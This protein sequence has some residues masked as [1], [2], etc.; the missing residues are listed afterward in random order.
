MEAFSI[1]CNGIL[2]L[3]QNLK[4][5][6]AFGP[7][8]LK[9]LLLKEL[10]EEIAPIIQIIFERSLQTGKLPADWCKAQ[11]I[12]VF[13]K[14]N[15]SSAANYRP[16]SL[17]CKLCKVLEHIIASHVVKHLNA[18]GLLYYLQYGFREKTSCETQLTMLVEDLARSVSQGKQT[19]L[20]LLDFSKAFDKV[21]HAKLLWKLHQYGLRGNALA[22][23]RAFLGNRSQTVVLD[24]EESGSVPV[25][26]GV[27]QGSV[28]GPILFLVYI[29]DLPDELSSQVRLFADDTT[30]YLTI[31]GAEDGKLLQNDLDRL[32][33]LEDR[34]DMEFNPSKCQVVRV[35]SSR[36]PFDFSYTLHGQVLE[37]VTSNK[38]LGVDISCISSG[39]SWNPHI[40]QISKNA[41]RTLNFIQR[42]IRTKNQKVRETAYLGGGGWGN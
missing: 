33:V 5:F 35:T 8:K 24:G 39:L 31:G 11:V 32:S 4:P 16:I 12:P 38:Y 15:K 27:P 42:N 28:L 21:N 19:D 6:K 1:S 14:G 25:T 30:V 34:W 3:L 18:H 10:R 22:W 2:K 40:D 36:N 26:S 37:V 9:L 23:I 7:D 41:T 29:N 17:T 13:N 20:I